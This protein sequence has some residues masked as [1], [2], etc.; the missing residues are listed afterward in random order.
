MAAQ[1]ASV[2][3]RLADDLHANHPGMGHVS[4]AFHE[5]GLVGRGESRLPSGGDKLATIALE[6]WML[7]EAF[8]LFPKAKGVLEA[9][10]AEGSVLVTAGD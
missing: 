5:S 6:I 2:V 4:P 10:L 7:V 1:Q 3:S 9:D 8:R